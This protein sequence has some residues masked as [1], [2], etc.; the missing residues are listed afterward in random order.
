MRNVLSWDS[1]CFRVNGK[2]SPLISGEFHYFR[3]PKE[4]W[5]TRLLLLKE[6]GANAVA[7]YIPWIVHEPEEGTILFDDVPQRCLTDFLRL[8]QELEI[9]V[10]ARP[11]PY[12]YSELCQHGLPAWLLDTYPQ[13]LACGPDGV[14]NGSD[15]SASYLH[16]VFLEKA[17][18]YLRAVNGLLRPFLVTNGGCVVSVQADNEIGG[19][20]VWFGFLDCNAQ[21]MGFGRPDGHYV[22]FLEEKYGTVDR[23]NARYGTRFNSFCEI[24][25]YRN[26]PKDDTVGGKRF[27]CDYLNFYK[28][29]LEIYIETLCGWF[30]ED[31]LD[32]DFCTNAGTPSFLPIMRNIPKQNEQYRFFLGADHYYALFPSSG[33][34]MTPEKM[35]RYTDSVDWQ[36][37]LGM[38]PSVLE[39]QS[40]S[41][42]CYPPIFP[43][44]AYGF[45]MAHVALGMKGSNY[46]VFTGGPNFENTGNNVDIY[47]YHAPVSATGEVRPLYDVQKKRNEFSHRQDWLLTESRVCDVQ[48]GFNW[49]SLQ[50]TVGGPWKRYS[51]DGLQLGRYGDSL[52]LTLSLG[53]RLYKSKEIGGALDPALPLIVAC[54][55][56][57]SRQKQENLVQ[58]VKKGGKLIL[59][60]VVPDLDEDFLPCTV[61]KDFLG[62]E[63]S[64]EI[65]AEGPA[66]LRNGQKVYEL[67]NKYTFPG[68]GG[69]VL[70]RNE[71]DGTSLA[72]VKQIGKGAVLLLGATYYYSQFCQ[73][74]LLNFCLDSLGCERRVHTDCRTLAVT[75]FENGKQGMV[76]LINNLPGA[77]TDS[78]TVFAN[79]KEYTLNDITV[80]SFSVVSL[81]LKE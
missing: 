20:H 46:Y 4:D 39:M 25:P 17:R 49:D 29:T 34:C 56:R 81:S 74:D 80:P 26:T 18:R 21:A 66:L 45:Y 40:G 24:A 7:T 75:L 33:T 15:R 73:M 44:N 16:P 37:A 53:A 19:I 22:Q 12:S 13:V 60:P 38:P 68:F 51:R 43:E 9:M 77:V 23:L 63:D 79:G 5:R 41:A 62:V 30:A 57:M 3:V 42:S 58:F 78:F 59:T 28:R 65:S 50:E 76:F 8:C 10:I 14:R 55:Q 69:T 47:D 32:V 36:E 2:P 70:L 52:R 35:V 6:S 72:E 64:S 27:A 48:Y 61:L 71:A 54:D 1:A 67:K 11:G 31:G